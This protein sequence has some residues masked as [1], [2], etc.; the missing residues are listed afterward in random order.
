MENATK[1]L[2]IA[3]SVLIAI[4]I[5]GMLFYFSGSL[6]EYPKAQEIE[7]QK[8]QVTR[9]NREY[10]SYNKKKMY[11]TDVVTVI[12]KAIDNNKK[13]KNTFTGVMKKDD[14]FYYIDVE[15]KL[16]PTSSIVAYAEVYTQVNMNIGTGTEHKYVDMQRIDS[17]TLA[18][19]KLGVVFEKGAKFYIL[20]DLGDSVKTN[21]TVEEF[22]DKFETIKIPNMDGKLDEFNYTI[23]YSGFADFKRKYFTCETIEYNAETGRV[24]RLV[25]KEIKGD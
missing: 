23:V 4:V 11:G 19:H 2:M 17:G 24:N 1:G 25:F 6:N 14:S 18:G 8:E 10:E 5:I 15:V 20:E 9:F 21:K 22:F 13:Y 3:G 7:R 12:N 16:L